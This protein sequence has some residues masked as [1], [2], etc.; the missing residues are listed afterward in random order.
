[1]NPD[2]GTS[3][4]IDVADLN[5]IR[6]PWISDTFKHDYIDSLS[7][8]NA[9]LKYNYEDLFILKIGVSYLRSIRNHS[10]RR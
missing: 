2:N 10:L 7:S 4:R 1:M 8:R 5:Y 3:W 6:M 9:I